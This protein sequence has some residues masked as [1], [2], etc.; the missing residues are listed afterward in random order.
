MERAWAALSVFD[1]TVA[2]VK[3]PASMHRKHQS[4]PLPQQQLPIGSPARGS[5]SQQP[6]GSG[7]KVPL[8]TPFQPLFEKVM[9]VLNDLHVFFR[10]VP[11]W[12]ALTPTHSMHVKHLF[13]VG[14]LLISMILLLFACPFR[15]QVSNIR[16]IF[17][18]HCNLF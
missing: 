5:V 13:Q 7:G 2:P 10:S 17:S 12:N 4:H 16:C 3:S 6:G 15:L 14:H 18:F 8:V 1:S 9:S 11:G